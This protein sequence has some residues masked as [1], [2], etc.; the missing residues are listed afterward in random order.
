MVSPRF[1]QP[2]ALPP[3]S[4]LALAG[5]STRSAPPLA[6][7][8]LR[9]LQLPHLRSLPLARTS[10]GAGSPAETRWW[11]PAW[12]AAAW[13]SGWAPL[14]E[15]QSVVGSRAGDMD[16]NPPRRSARLCAGGL[17]LRVFHRRIDRRPH[18]I[19]LS[20]RG[21]RVRISCSAMTPMWLARTARG[22]SDWNAG[23]SSPPSASVQ[24]STLV[25][26]LPCGLV[27]IS[28]PY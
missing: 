7:P 15:Q 22:P 28:P 23:A 12:V 25:G 18:F 13:A 6:C 20:R 19:L 24:G 17:L 3:G 4:E 9:T 8:R 26:S 2:S 16:L 1:G 11:A 21:D 10:P 5:L 14:Q 27:L